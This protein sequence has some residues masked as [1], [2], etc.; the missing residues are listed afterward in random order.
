MHEHYKKYFANMIL[1]G[2]SGLEKEYANFYDCGRLF[3]TWKV[4]H[5]HGSVQFYQN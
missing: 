4:I 2:K 3:K 1:M 5:A